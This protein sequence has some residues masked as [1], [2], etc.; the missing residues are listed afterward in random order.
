[1]WYW[2][3]VP[4]HHKVGGPRQNSVKHQLPTE[5]LQLIPGRLAS[6]TVLAVVLVSSCY[7]TWKTTKNT[8][9]TSPYRQVKNRCSK[10][11]QWKHKCCVQSY[12]EKQGKEKNY[13]LS[14]KVWSV[15]WQKKTW[16]RFN[17]SI[18]A[19]FGYAKPDVQGPS[20]ITHSTQ[21]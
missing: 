2:Q 5:Y 3:F 9:N 7:I 6:H 11:R 4:C 1:M 19:C 18:S 17:F 21:F 20:P 8:L 12:E 16:T 14:A 13:S 15:I 10:V